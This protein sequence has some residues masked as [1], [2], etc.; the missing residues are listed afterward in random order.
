MMSLVVGGK[1]ITE[2][3]SDLKET[4]LA[5]LE[6]NSELKS[7]IARSE[8]TQTA[9]FELLSNVQKE[10][11]DVKNEF[12]SFK[13]M[14]KR[15]STARPNGFDYNILSPVMDKLELKKKMSA[16]KL[17]DYVKINVEGKYRRAAWKAI[18]AELNSRV[19]VDIIQEHKE[20]TKNISKGERG[21]KPYRI[22]DTVEQHGLVNLAMECAREIV[23]NYPSPKGGQ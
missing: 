1:H 3:I 16:Q 15:S 2:N 13:E 20:R 23:K 6:E 19:D 21:K 11:R 17:C 4:T 9:T 12:S 7:I 8:A 18:Y 22:A 5:L 14:F 10:L